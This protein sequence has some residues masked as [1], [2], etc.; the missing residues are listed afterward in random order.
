MHQ[1]LACRK[2]FPVAAQLEG[3]GTEVVGD[4]AQCII[5]VICHQAMETVLSAET[6]H[7]LMVI[8][9]ALCNLHREEENFIR[10]MVKLVAACSIADMFV[11]KLEKLQT[12][13]KSQ[14][15]KKS[16]V[17]TENLCGKSDSSH[18][19]SVTYDPNLDCKLSFHSCEVQRSPCLKIHRAG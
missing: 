12:I 14:I 3:M 16:I 7:F 17:P 15:V 2:T 13:Q 9:N 18:L 5:G 8:L 6:N 11:H 10:C 4:V 1:I 19:L